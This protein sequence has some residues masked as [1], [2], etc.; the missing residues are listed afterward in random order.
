MAF[1]AHF[2]PKNLIFCF[3]THQKR[4]KYVLFMSYHLNIQFVLFLSPYTSL[5]STHS[6]FHTSTILYSNGTSSSSLKN[7]IFIH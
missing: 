3:N 1:S 6:I 5:K 7:N 2:S 4:K